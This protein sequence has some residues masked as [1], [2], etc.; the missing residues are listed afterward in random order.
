MSTPALPRSHAPAL[1]PRPI[2]APARANRRF[3]RNWMTKTETEPAAFRLPSMRNLSRAERKSVTP[4]RVP[5]AAPAEG[6][7]ETSGTTP[8]S[9][10]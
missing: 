7:R 2:L 10:T 3:P 5:D 9:G 1:A 4:R 6:F 8:K